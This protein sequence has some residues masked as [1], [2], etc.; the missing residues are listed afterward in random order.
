MEQ[1]LI[2]YAAYTDS[3]L[4]SEITWLRTQIRN[5][6]AA[7]AEGNRSYQRSTGEFRDRL[8]AASQVKESR[9]QAVTH[10]RHGI[11]DFSQVRV[12]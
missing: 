1:W 2:A 9:A 10:P 11:A 4:D 12:R 5:P 6:Y 8:A 3:D 7:Q